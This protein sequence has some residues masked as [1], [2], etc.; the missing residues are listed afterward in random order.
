MGFSWRGDCGSA[1]SCQ[2]QSPTSS[3]HQPGRS[4][5]M[6]IKWTVARVLSLQS[7]RTSQPQC[8]LLVPM[9]FNSVWG[10]TLMAP[11]AALC[12]HTSIG[13]HCSLLTPVVIFLSGNYV[14]EH[15]SSVHAQKPALPSVSTGLV[16]KRKL[17]KT[18]CVECLGRC[19]AYPH[20][21][22][23]ICKRKCGEG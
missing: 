23:F 15:T 21:T 4:G 8:S 7:C 10:Q 12:R 18:K 22:K 3:D 14:T 20:S 11:T 5:V 16:N 17:N 9:L 6:T 1:R 13:T 19:T 2:R